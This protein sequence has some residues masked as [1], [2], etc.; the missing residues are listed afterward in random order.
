MTLCVNGQ[1]ASFGSKQTIIEVYKQNNQDLEKKQFT[2]IN[3]RLKNINILK[4]EMS[5]K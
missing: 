2:Q 3:D 4:E 5:K 1:K